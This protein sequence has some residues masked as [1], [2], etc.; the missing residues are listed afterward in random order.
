MTLLAVEDARLGWPGDDWPHDFD[1]PPGCM[2][3]YCQQRWSQRHHV[4]R[5]SATGGPRRFVSIDGLVVPNVVGL[6]DIHHD[7]LTGLVGG[8]RAAIVFPP[9]PEIA[10]DLY[11]GWWVWYGAPAPGCCRLSGLEPRVLKSGTVLV[12]YDYVKGVVL[13]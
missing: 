6:C 1:I 10:R 8:H 5:R 7:Q 12:A 3:P 13:L 4:V 9:A 2:H 11:R